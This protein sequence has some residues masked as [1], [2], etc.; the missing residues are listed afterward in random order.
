MYFLFW[1]EY[2]V[3]EPRHNRE[4]WK[5]YS[6]KKI[7]DVLFLFLS[8]ML[9]HS[10][11]WRNI[12]NVNILMSYIWSCR[13]HFSLWTILRELKIKII[14]HW[15]NFLSS[16]S[17]L[18]SILVIY[19]HLDKNFLW[20]AI[21]LPSPHINSFQYFRATWIFYLREHEMEPCL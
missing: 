6:I 16:L 2:R 10:I 21:Q 18:F 19:T 15:Q 20:N 4:I 17:N 7:N 5:H 12:N 1:G 9:S 13:T 14:V 11:K 3:S 8:K